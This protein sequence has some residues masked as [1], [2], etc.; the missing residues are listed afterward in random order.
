MQWIRIS[1]RHQAVDSD[2]CPI[3]Q[4]IFCLRWSSKLG[5][6]LFFCLFICVVFNIVV[7][8]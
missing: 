3:Y 1:K 8:S 4:W 7:S 2:S 5:L 6:S